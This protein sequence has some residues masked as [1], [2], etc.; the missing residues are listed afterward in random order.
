MCEYS[1]G[2]GKDHA[3]FVRKF[4]K[5]EDPH[6]LLRHIESALSSRFDIVWE[7]SLTPMMNREIILRYLDSRLSDDETDE[8][9]LQ[10]SLFAYFASTEMAAVSRLLS[11]LFLTLCLPHRYLAGKTHEFE[12]YFSLFFFSR[13]AFHT[14]TS[15][16]RLTSL[17]RIMTGE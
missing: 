3:E 11:I 14:V 13:S 6:L 10:R 5:E 9:I 4:V 12:Y 7:G 15:Q 2:H 17:G 1:K 8:G 16:A